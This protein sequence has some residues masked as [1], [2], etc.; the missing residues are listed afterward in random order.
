MTFSISKDYVFEQVRMRVAYIGVKSGDGR[1]L[2][3]TEADTPMLERLWAEAV[4]DIVAAVPSLT[5]STAEGAEVG[6]THPSNRGD[7]RA[8]LHRYLIS[9]IVAAWLR[10][11]GVEADCDDACSEAAAYLRRL[12][13]PTTRPMRP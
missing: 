1:R 6:C 9:H 11:C 12:C 4:T 8:I 13:A 2:L 3:L 5:V 10:L 7:L